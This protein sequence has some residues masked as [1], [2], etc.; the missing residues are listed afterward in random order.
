MKG[1]NIGT[2]KSFLTLISEA[3][4]DYK[5]YALSDQDDIWLPEKL[6]N[7]VDKLE[8]VGGD[9]PLLY[10]SPVFLFKDGKKGKV[11]FE[12][13]RDY[14][15]GN[16]IVK[17]YFPGC[18]VVFN[19]ELKELV[20]KVDPMKL[21]N[22]P[23]HDHWINLVCTSCGGEVIVDQNAYIYYRQHV[24]NVVGGERS[25]LDKII[26]NWILVKSNIRYNHVREL[27]EFYGNY[28]SDKAK[29]KIEKVLNYQ[30]SVKGALSLAFDKDIK[31]T[32]TIEKCAI[33]VNV[34]MGKF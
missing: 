3:P 5:Y 32:K 27:Y 2:K 13:E 16:F 14:K 29:K 10:G 24:N 25:I 23:L 21:E 7:G 4:K 18:T 33:F 6:S 1:N 11:V 19:R 12:K 31:P 30:R 28:M 15:F 26:D 20:E 17:N 8:E 22:T 34:L 9:I